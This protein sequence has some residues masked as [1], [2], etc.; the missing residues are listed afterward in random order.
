MSNDYVK[1]LQQGVEKE[2]PSGMVVRLR[3][4]DSSILLGQDLPKPLM[5]IVEKH[6]GVARSAATAAADAQSEEAAALEIV[7]ENG[8]VQT[9][10]DMRAF[11]AVVARS[12]FVYP[13]VVENPSG[14]NEISADWMSTEDLIAITKIIGMPLVHLIPFRFIEDK[15]LEP[16]RPVEVSLSA[17]EPGAEPERMGDES[18]RT[19][20]RLVDQLPV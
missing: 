5:Q 2:L 4:V 14:D 18:D 11:G 3:P 12:C 1:A 9:M 19:P 17:T 6:M 13:K 16:V 15:S 10:L 20:E 7:R 8:A